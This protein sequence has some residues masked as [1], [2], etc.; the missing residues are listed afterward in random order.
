MSATKVSLHIRLTPEAK[1]LAQKA[2]AL[3]L[4]SLSE[5]I[6]TLITNSA[7]GIIEKHTNIKLSNED[8]DSFA[9]YFDKIKDIEIPESFMKYRDDNS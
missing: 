3:E 1:L 8:F 7:P 4:I 2:S 6:S 9:S 5:Y